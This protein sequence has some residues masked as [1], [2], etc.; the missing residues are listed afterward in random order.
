[1]EVKIEE[2]PPCKKRILL[3]TYDNYP[4]T[5]VNIVY[6]D[7]HRWCVKLGWGDFLTPQELRK[8][9]DIL[10]KYNNAQKSTTPKKAGHNVS[11]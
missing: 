2:Y 8:I 10:D 3:S 9:A 1:M 4:K 5:K 11:R 6:E 7:T